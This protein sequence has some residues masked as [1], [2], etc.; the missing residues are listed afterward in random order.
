[1]KKKNIIFALALTMAFS[2]GAGVVATATYQPESIYASADESKTAISVV[3]VNY[4]DNL[5]GGYGA[6]IIIGFGSQDLGLGYWSAVDTQGKVTLTGSDGA[7]KTVALFESCGSSL[8]VN[9]DQSYVASVGDILTLKAGLIV[10]KFELKEDVSYKYETANAPWVLYTGQQTPAEEETALGITTVEGL[11]YP[12]DANVVNDLTWGAPAYLINFASA[13]TFG[14]YESAATMD[15]IEFTN[16]Y[17]E[18]KNVVDCINVGNTHF[19]IRWSSPDAPVYA[20]VGDKI[21]FKKGFALK[22][23]EKMQEDVTFIVVDNNGTKQLAPYTED[24]AASG[25]SITTDE[26]YK[27]ITAGATAQMTYTIEKGYGTA[28]FTSSDESVATVS[29]DGLVTGV[30][31]GD[32]TITVHLGEETATF[33]MKVLP[34]SAVVGIEI[35]NQYTVYVLRNERLRFP[36]LKA[37]AKFENG[38]TGSEFTLD[39][40]NFTVPNVDTS[41]TGEQ[42]VS[43]TV[44]YQGSEYTVEFTVSVYE[45]VDISIKEVAIVD[46]FS[47]ALFVQYPDSTANTANITDNSKFTDVL[48]YL[49]YERADGE[50]VPLTGCY[51]LSGGNLALFPFSGLDENNYNDYYLVGD[52]LT[53]RAGFTTWKW[54]G[55]KAPTATDNNAIAEGTG[56][57]VREGKL[58]EDVVFRYDGNVWG[59]YVEYTDVEA[60]S[61]EITV[62]AG[63]S[64][65]C[66]VSRVPSNATTGKFTYITSDENIATVS[67]RGI[68]KGVSAGTCTITVILDGGTAGEKQVTINVTVTDEITGIEISTPSISVELGGTPDLS[69][70]AATYKWASGKAGESVDL[71]NATLVGFD[72]NQAGEQSVVVS[73]TVDGK[74]YTGTLT[75]VVT[76]NAVTSGDG[77]T[78]EGGLM[79]GS[80]TG[81]LGVTAALTLLGAGVAMGKKRRK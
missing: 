58:S 70:V 52:T 8:V 26:Q 49:T 24:M 62:E 7:A 66:N 19:L 46:W 32:V 50:L 33:A 27:E 75:V 20:M 28:Y 25:V 39:A 35:P 55:E 44:I 34:A 53:L 12:Y 64:A 74:E 60:E 38:A 6:C 17:G 22:G 16:A 4:S 48:E 41:E 3:D 36:E 56:M 77:Q 68:V 9:R 40:D 51:I 57:Y 23:N 80:V 71:T 21:T 61:S 5:L 54:T 15:L 79:C 73:V 37:R 30:A 18:K 13:K 59:L 69:Q 10:G 78:S 45:L 11:T 72:A 43:T 67:A 1:M 65:D 2:A 76:D 29:K 63:K 47:Y 81:A 14:T 42:T 31:E